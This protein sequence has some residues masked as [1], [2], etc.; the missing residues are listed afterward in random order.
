MEPNWFTK[1]FN[2]EYLK[3]KGDELGFPMSTIN[4]Y[5]LRLLLFLVCVWIVLLVFFL[6]L[7]ACSTP[8]SKGRSTAKR[9][10]HATL[11]PS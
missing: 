11:R 6:S 9:V 4:K 2:K 1:W 10:I 8:S 7:K 3:K 5:G